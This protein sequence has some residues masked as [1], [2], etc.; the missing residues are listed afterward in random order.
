[1]AFLS[2]EATW[3]DTLC[4]GLMCPEMVVRTTGLGFGSGN[5]TVSWL[6]QQV[7]ERHVLRIHL[8]ELHS[9]DHH[10]GSGV[11]AMAALCRSPKLS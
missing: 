3:S 8:A 9:V 7:V 1:M 2:A 4:R 5:A 11:C 10:I 6:R